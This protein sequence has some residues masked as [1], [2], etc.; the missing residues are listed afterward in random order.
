MV[1]RRAVTLAGRLQGAEIE[2]ERVAKRRGGDDWD[3]DLEGWKATHKGGCSQR[4]AASS[5]FASGESASFALPVFP[6]H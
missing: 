5:Y 3:D 6:R 1:R 2:E 4:S